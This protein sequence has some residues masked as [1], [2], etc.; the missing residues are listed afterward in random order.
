MPLSSRLLALAVALG[1]ALA[2]AADDKAACIAAAEGG[3]DLRTEGKL[4][5]AREQLVVCTQAICPDVIRKDCTKFLADVEASIPSIVVLA[6]GPDGADLHDARTR[7]DGAVVSEK[8]EGKAILVDPGRHTVRVEA[9][10][11]TYAEVEVVLAEGDKNRKVVVAFPRAKAGATGAGATDAAPRAERSLTAPLVV[12]GVGA[13]VLAGSLWLGFVARGEIADMRAGCAPHCDQG[14]LD[15][16]RRKLLLADVGL[17]VSA[18][19]LA[20]AT[21]LFVTAP[22]R[23]NTTVGARW[24]PSG[25]VLTFQAVF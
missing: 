5:A 23:P 9:S 25:G 13:A 4:R 17:G 2:Q 6:T 11:G 24:V 21:Y 20:A 12:G 14:A 19:A 8:L 1:P 10:D 16:S 15:D 22:S 18:V 3:Q 7:V